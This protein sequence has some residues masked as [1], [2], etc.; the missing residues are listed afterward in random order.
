MINLV[1]L[2]T[3]PALRAGL[4]A[5]IVSDPDFAVIA[6]GSSLAA[7]AGIPADT[8]VLVIT[9][10]ALADGAVRAFS[11]RPDLPVLVIV[12]GELD[13]QDLAGI[14][15]GLPGEIRPW[16]VIS[17][18][19]PAEALQAAVRAVAEG[20]MVASPELLQSLLS[21]V[22]FEPEAGE[23]DQSGLTGREHLTE[24]EVDV[25]R[26]V[27]R[28]LTNKQIALALGISEHTV[29]FH[30]SSVYAKLGASNRTE[31]VRKGARRGFIPL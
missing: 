10:D 14:G 27:A 20:L 6:T 25:L 29:K 22:L 1:I 7:L 13:P 19:A 18:E 16:G 3:I 4:R 12:E 17:A 2:S 21:P 8:H 28:G 11:A 5:L 15:V 26:E 23:Y 24:R 30:V 9:R 31:A